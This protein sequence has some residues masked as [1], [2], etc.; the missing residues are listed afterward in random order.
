MVD[1][2]FWNGVFITQDPRLP[3]AEAV[4]VRGERIVAAG[5]LDEIQKMSGA[6]TE[7][8]DL[9]GRAVVPGFND[10]HV[11]VW[12]VGHLLTGMLDLRGAKSLADI[13]SKIRERASKA[14][15]NTWILGRGYNEAWM[16]EGRGPTRLDLDPVSPNHPVY[17]TRTCGH[18]AVANTKALEIAGLS[19]NTS[20]PPGGVIVRNESGEATGELHETAMGIVGSKVPDLSGAEFEAA[21]IAGARHQLSL[22]I[23]SATEAGVTPAQLAVY[24]DM[25]ARGALPY[26]V[27]AMALRRPLGS[28]ET[29][30]LPVPLHSDFLRID[31]IKIL[32]DGGLSGATA[33]LREPYR[34]SCSCGVLRAGGDELIELT[35]DAH[36]AGL[37]VGVHAIGDAAI[38]AV[39]Y[40]FEAL[41]RMAPGPRHRLE[42]FGLPHEAQIARAAALGA[43]AVPQAIFIHTLGRNFRRYLPDNLLARAYP[44]RDMIAGGLI[45]ALS[46]DA[47]VVAD[48]NPLLGIQAAILRTDDEGVV[49]AGDQAI[50]ID[51]ALFAYTMGGALASGDE[52]NRGSLSPG[53]WADMA[54]LSADPRA[55]PPEALSG[56]RVDRT[57]LGGQTVFER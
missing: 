17:L 41:A 7:H 40:A 44:I 49:I 5:S 54:V 48:D 51:E 25:D 19:A 50:S 43:I 36:M 23:T 27:N 53:K 38:D 28:P 22:G 1:K 6:P 24:R 13:E 3:I 14:P 11:H 10:A 12:K 15:P 57:I 32:A 56:I 35:K 45:T 55:V 33:A 37:R 8:I 16:A 46:S 2:I 31:T 21:V 34:G 42:H 29:L 39:L 47:P 20:A 18:I 52:A 4:A 9:G 30:P 26:R